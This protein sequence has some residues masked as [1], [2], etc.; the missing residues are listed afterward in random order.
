[1]DEPNPSAE[2]REEVSALLRQCGGELW[3]IIAA[4]DAQSRPD[5][6]KMREAAIQAIHDEAADTED[7]ETIEALNRATERVR[8]LMIEGTSR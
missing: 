1:M 2:R 8:A 5:V 7:G 3:S 6:E 4:L